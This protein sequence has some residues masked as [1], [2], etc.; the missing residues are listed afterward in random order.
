MLAVPT[1]RELLRQ[2]PNDMDVI[3]RLVDAH[4][5]AGRPERARQLLEERLPALKGAARRRG[6]L[7]LATTL[8]RDG[9]T[10]GAMTLF[11]TL[12]QTEPDDPLPLVTLARLPD[13]MQRCP[14]LEQFVADWTSRH[15]DDTAMP[16]SV[17][18]ALASRRDERGLQSAESILRSILKRDPQSVSA[19][20]I[21]ADLTLQTGRAEESAA[22]NR[23][24][25]EVAP[26]N[27]IALNNL[28]WFLCEEKGQYE[29][30]LEFA[31]RGLRAA[32][33]YLD[34]I[35]T[36]GVIRYR[37]G[38]FEEAVQDFSKFIELCPSHVRSLV[39]TRFHLARAYAEMGRK[40]EARQELEEILSA[41]NQSGGL[42]PNDLADAKVLLE[43]L[44]KGS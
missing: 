16:T 9:D 8:Y 10:Q 30:A 12:M 41:Q 17:A 43:Q 27:V 38:H 15:P 3:A 4:L 19:L 32:P 29:E 34:L 13:V 24:I 36:R 18:A 5:E 2:D 28:A 31:D 23:K 7:T 39:I 22:A 25:L 21:L 44:E 14:E 1:L 33:E 26:N 6:D 42:P 11:R 20:L 35:D 40:T 37:M